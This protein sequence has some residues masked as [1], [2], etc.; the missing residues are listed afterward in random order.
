MKRI[1]NI[2]KKLLLSVMALTLL[3]A[4]CGQPAASPTPI[5]VVPEPTS[6]TEPTREPTATVEPTPEPVATF[7]EA[8]CPFDV[9][10]DPVVE[11]GFVVVP[12]DHNDPA[13][14]TIRLSVAILKDQSEEHQPDPV[15]LLSGG[16]G[17]KTVHN[18][19][20]IAQL[21]APVHPNRDLIVFDQRGVGLSE[22]ALECPESVQAAFDLLD[23]PDPDVAL[24]TVF[25][26]V[27]ACRD[28]LVSEG[29][30]LSAYNTVQNAA[31]VSAIRTALGYDQINLWG[32]SYGSLLAQ[33][34]MRAHPEGIRSVAIVSILPLEK[35]FF[36]EAST[37]TTNA[38][39]RLL[40]ACADDE[41]CHSAYPDLQE[42][43][44]EVIDQLNAEPVPITVTNPLD[45]QSYD[46]I[47][48]GDEVLGNLVT[49]LYFTQIIPVLPQAIH[50]VHNG[51]YGLMTQLSSIT[52]ALFELLS[53]GMTFSVMCTDDLIG[54][55]PEDLL[56]IM[57]ALPRQLQGRADPELVI[58][59]GIF[60]I[61]ENWPVEEADLWVKEPLVSDIPTLV[62]TGEFDPVT[63]PEYGQLVAR[64]LSDSYF[65]ELPGIGHDILGAS[66]CA[67][68]II[69][70]FIADPTQLPDASCIAEMPGVV[71]DLPSEAGEVV[72]EPV[73]YEDSG[74][75]GLLPAGWTD[76]ALPRNY[77]RDLTALDPTTLVQDAIPMTAD[78]LLGLLAKQLGFDPG[79]ESA[80]SAESGSFVWDLYSF[81]YQ[82]YRADLA[83][84]E[85]DD[86]A[87]FVL[88]I[89]PP[90]E[91]DDLYETVFLPV[92]DAL[93]PRE[94][95]GEFS[96]YLTTQ[97]APAASL[98][99]ASLDTLELENQP[100]LS[101]DDVLRYSRETHEIVLTSP[102]YERINQL[103]VPTGGRG[104]VVCVGNERIYTG[105][106][107]PL[108]SSQS[109]D[110][111]VIEVP[112]VDQSM[113]IQ[114]GY[115][116]PLD[117]FKG[118]DFRSDVRI[119]Q[120]LERAGNLE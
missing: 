75:S 86:K 83:L 23:E 30:N 49:F 2:R 55:T 1:T 6:T 105:A 64:Y 51:D 31:D 98:S 27:M 106:F 33:A 115:P 24:Q 9:P 14:P 108:F 20:A 8:D 5:E 66:E 104:F 107:W 7:E 92:V 91:R 26:A 112:L 38:V 13:G 48:T 29:H 89:S 54:R 21:L 40:D 18:A 70:D 35:S 43:L 81:E 102:A 85:D 111:V 50:D 10:E 47:L 42:V 88:L 4:S 100:I 103:S 68:S 37:T 57:A 71:F 120:S 17:E 90:D 73:T 119:L 69:G 84:A 113:R 109:S 19:P 11:C 34:T 116:E 63:P 59:H 28:R 16:P 114:V 117:L 56:N 118:E 93:V 79:L 46:S 12:E 82:S 62:L 101:G 58:E 15:I 60:G 53:R 97:E 80:A 76:E 78:E 96:I 25:D 41:A 45:G 3:L 61:C 94:S 87:Y 99:Q 74:F 22:P 36:V 44:F 65:F 52:L 95:V 39:M 32:G 72:L 110:G 77:R 67:R